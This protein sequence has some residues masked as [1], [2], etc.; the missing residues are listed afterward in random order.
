MKQNVC[1]QMHYII[2]NIIFYF[3]CFVKLANTVIVCWNRSIYS[4]YRWQRRSVT[5][6]VLIASGTIFTWRWQLIRCIWHTTFR[7]RT[8]FY[9]RKR[10]M[11]FF[12][13]NFV[14]YYLEMNHRLFCDNPALARQFADQFCWLQYAC[15]S[16]D[17]FRGQLLKKR[18]DKLL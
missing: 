10:W 15:L 4:G 16:Y 5:I 7:I 2:H 17:A 1:N 11:R 8:A 13:F 3:F 14:A 9:K 12:F 6:T 18:D